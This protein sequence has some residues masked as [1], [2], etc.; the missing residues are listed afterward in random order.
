M[1]F[2]VEMV[3]WVLFGALAGW[4][5]AKF[6]HLKTEFWGNTI[7]G[8]IGAII[9]GAIVELLGGAGITGFNVYSLVVAVI[10]GCLFT[11]IVRKLD[12]KGD[13]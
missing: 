9:G 5:T 13:L 10:G 12:K 1:D 8:V 6:M 7:L 11:W 3:A 2:L 4:L